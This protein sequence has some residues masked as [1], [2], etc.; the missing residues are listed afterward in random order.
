MNIYFIFIIVCRPDWKGFF[1][2]LKRNLRQ[3]WCLN[4]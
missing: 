3:T 4:F 2:K 1:N